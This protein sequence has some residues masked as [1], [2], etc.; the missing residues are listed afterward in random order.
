DYTTHDHRFLTALSKTEHKVFFLRLEGSGPVLEYRPQPPGI[1]AVEWAGGKKPAKLGDGL[2]LLNDLRRVI[3]QV[4]PDLIHA[5]P[6][7]RAAFLAALAGFH[8]LVSM[9]WGYDLLHD[10]KLNIALKW[11]T[12][13]TLHRSDA[14]VGDCDTIRNLAISYGMQPKRIVTFPWGID[15]QHFTFQ[16]RENPNRSPF[17]LLSTRSWEPIYGIDVIARAFS[18]ALKK[19]HDL[20]L[21]L[22]GG[23]SQYAPIRQILLVGA[24]FNQVTFPGQAPHSDLPA[25]YHQADL[26][27]SA[28]HS[29]GTSISL[30][31]AFATGTPAIVPD[32]PGNREWVIPG[33]NGWLF[34]DGDAEALASAIL[35]AVEQRQ[36]LPEMGRKARQLAE[37]RADWQK[38]FPQLEK[39]YQLALA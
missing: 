32:I 35:L 14:F 4:K 23:G 8:P 25:Y 27:I 9:S 11:A 37:E 30:L 29:D 39:A 16:P 22:L 28:S 15:L 36:R 10:A 20:Q 6:I 34:P 26:Y 24:A 21:T 3:R 5:G 19:R 31:E 13:Y 18:L 12:R 17:K 38:N 33:E 1:E 2:H 7:Q